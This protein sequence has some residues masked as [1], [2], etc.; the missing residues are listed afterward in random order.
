MTVAEYLALAIWEM[1]NITKKIAEINSKAS[2]MHSSFS[3]YQGSPL[4]Q[5]N[6]DN[7][8]NFYSET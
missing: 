3:H 7:I 5:S 2:S 4:H 8:L 6:T 1:N